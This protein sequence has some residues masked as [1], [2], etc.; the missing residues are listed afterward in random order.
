[1]TTT[2][3]RLGPD[4]WELAR[5]VRLDS[6]RDG[7]GGDSDFLREEAALDEVAWRE[8]LHRHARFAAL[9]D[10]GGGRAAVGT[11]GWR[12]HR[13]GGADA[14]HLYGMWVHPE[15][16]GTG[17]SR[18]LVGAVVHLS[19]E[20]GYAALD[21]KVEP[22]NAH[23]IAVY[24]RIGFAVVESPPGGLVVMRCPLP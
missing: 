16:R 20:Q 6:I 15:H 3:R 21:L 12:P 10:D 4:D 14:G 5:A 13:S 22:A 11:V 8:V 2:V 9:S 23:A 24:R 17:L 19:R 7:F 1:M 18:L